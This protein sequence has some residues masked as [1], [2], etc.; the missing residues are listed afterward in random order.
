[1]ITPSIAGLLGRWRARRA[2]LS[3]AA[4]SRCEL[5]LGRGATSEVGERFGGMNTS[6]GDGES[7]WTTP[8]HTW[9]VGLLPEEVLVALHGAPGAEPR[10]VRVELCEPDRSSEREIFIDARPNEIVLWQR[11]RSSWFASSRRMV[12]APHPD[13][14]HL[15]LEPTDYG[16]TVVGTFRRHPSTRMYLIVMAALYLVGIVWNVIVFPSGVFASAP[17]LFCIAFAVGAMLGPAFAWRQRYSRPTLV[18]VAHQQLARH[19]IATPA[20]PFR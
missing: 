1:M 20:S 14:L 7:R 5:P 6:R 3:Y 13:T 15:R 9:R 11:P 8:A 19:E 12:L 2:S 16:T 18:S 4:R 10:P 17:W